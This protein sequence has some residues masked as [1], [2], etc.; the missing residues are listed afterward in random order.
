MLALYHMSAQLAKTMHTEI[1]YHGSGKTAAA[2]LL[3]RVS[4]GPVT[5]EAQVPIQ[6]LNQKPCSSNYR[7]GTCRKQIEAQC[8][9][10][11]RHFGG[12]RIAAR[13]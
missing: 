3:G 11:H 8:S 12:E 5:A 2:D 6:M 1:S 4:P 13:F 7:F 10:T 9:C